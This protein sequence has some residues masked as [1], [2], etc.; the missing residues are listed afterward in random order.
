MREGSVEK[1]MKVVIIKNEALEVWKKQ[2]YPINI[3]ITRSNAHFR[4]MVV[5]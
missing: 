1:G 5:N 4:G 3:I 2:K